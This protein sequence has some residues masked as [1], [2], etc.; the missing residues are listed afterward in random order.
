M[1]NTNKR[2]WKQKIGRIMY[3]LLSILFFALQISALFFMWHEGYIQSLSGIIYAVAYL[4]FSYIFLNCKTA[5]LIAT[6][7]TPCIVFKIL[8]SVHMFDGLGLITLSVVIMIAYNIIFRCLFELTVI[9][10]GLNEHNPME[11]S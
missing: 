9:L 4:L 5:S 2:A 1:D 11:K 6:Y 8:L 3:A 7:F 10:F